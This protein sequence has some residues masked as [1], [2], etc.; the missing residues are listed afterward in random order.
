MSFKLIF[1]EA[2][3]GTFNCCISK[4]REQVEMNPSHAF[5]KPV[6]SIQVQNDALG[7]WVTGYLVVP[8]LA[9][10]SYAAK[11]TMELEH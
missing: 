11:I 7:A 3:R 8:I 10:V 4:F 2:P 6:I 9:K 1:F 5:R